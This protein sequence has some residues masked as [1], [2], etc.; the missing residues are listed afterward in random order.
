MKIFLNYFQIEFFFSLRFEMT[1]YELVLMWYNRNWIHIY[2][3]I[4]E[5]KKII[6]IEEKI[7]EKEKKTREEWEVLP[8]KTKTE[9]SRNHPTLEN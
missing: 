4:L 1:K 8:T 3:Y 7:Q 2:I 5:T 6:L 9:Q